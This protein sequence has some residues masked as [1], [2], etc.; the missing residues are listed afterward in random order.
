[1]GLWGAFKSAR[2]FTLPE[3]VLTMAI[4]TVFFSLTLVTL[5]KAYKTSLIRS[6]S[7]SV[8]SAVSTANARARNGLYGKYWGVFFDY[9]NGTRAA[10]QAV[11]FACDSTYASVPADCYT[12]RIAAYDV[13]YSLNPRPYFYWVDLAG[14]GATTGDDHYIVFTPLTGETGQYGSINLA[15]T[16]LGIH[17]DISPLGTPSR[18]FR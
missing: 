7:D 2:G 13:Y 1:M 12:N 11:V 5:V 10:T 6:T 14:G 18:E 8:T 16:E 17:I 3:L 4:M 9:D 15:G